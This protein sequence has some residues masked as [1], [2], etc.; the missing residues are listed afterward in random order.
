MS[1]KASFFIFN[2]IQKILRGK[3]DITMNYNKFDIIFSYYLFHSH[4]QT[5]KWEFKK[6]KNRLKKPYLKMLV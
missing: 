1:D 2:I 4:K 6:M 3:F 5:L